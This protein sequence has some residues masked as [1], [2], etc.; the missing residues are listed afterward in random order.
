MTEGNLGEAV[1]GL[2]DSRRLT[3]RGLAELTGFSPSFLSQVETGAASPSIASME[4]IA[5]ALGVTLGQFFVSAEARPAAIVRAGGRAGL[6]SQW[7]KG[8]VES[9][10]NGGS[11]ALEAILVTLERG[12]TSAKRPVASSHEEFAI[13]ISGRIE[14]MLDDAEQMLA[15]GD[16]AVIHTGVARR[17]RNPGPMPAQIVIVTGIAARV[18][19]RRPS[20]GRTRLTARANR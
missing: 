4:R 19:A 10:T 12:G 18:G 3:L 2:R 11:S 1:R 20:R 7:S 16:S 13:V 15:T 8:R 17:W 6:S 9:L 5:T 14:L